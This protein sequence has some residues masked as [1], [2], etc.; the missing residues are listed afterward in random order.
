MS[1]DGGPNYCSALVSSRQ[2]MACTKS[3]EGARAGSEELP[4]EGNPRAYRHFE[5]ASSFPLHQDSRLP[6]E[7][8]A[9]GSSDMSQ[10]CRRA[11]LRGAAVMLD[12][13][14]RSRR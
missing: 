11:F 2:G 13:S 10:W 7:S 4:C 14:L 1:P 6:S 3:E 8:P 5:L 12:G 9:W